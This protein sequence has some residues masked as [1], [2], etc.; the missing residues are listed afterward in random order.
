[1]FA[2]FEG[3]EAFEKGSNSNMALTIAHHP[4]LAF[5][6]MKFGT[7]LLSAP[8]LSPRLREMVALYI[9]WRNKAE[10]EWVQHVAIGRDAGISDEEMNA[11]KLDPEAF[12]WTE[13][14]RNV[15]RAT[16]Q[17]L[18]HAQVDDQTWNGLAAELDKQQLIE[19]LFVIG[20][21]GMLSWI[22]NA[23]GIQPETNAELIETMAH[24]RKG[25]IKT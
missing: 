2:F 13:L 6:Y 18:S 10:Y 16:E 1:M 21:Y 14:E 22:I 17:L 5:A 3:P 15:L 19:L 8:K 20:N 7:R 9:G 23:F 12:N 24:N 25:R 11:L 4:K